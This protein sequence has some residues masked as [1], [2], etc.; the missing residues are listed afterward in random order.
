MIH[1]VI[2]SSQHANIGYQK[3]KN[4]RNWVYQRNYSVSHEKKQQQPQTIFQIIPKIISLQ[5]RG[6]SSHLCPQEE[7][8]QTLERMLEYIH[9]FIQPPL[10]GEN[11]QKQR[12]VGVPIPIKGRHVKKSSS[13]LLR[14]R[15]S[16][17]WRRK[18]NFSK[19]QMSAECKIRNDEY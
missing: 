16:R 8:K 17:V 11:E 10:S 4:K 5:K 18:K 15:F 2:A 3:T 1:K 6:R 7:A 19:V 14:L 9:S 12:C 13:Y